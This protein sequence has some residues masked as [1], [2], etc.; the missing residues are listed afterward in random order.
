MELW[1]TL[2][3]KCARRCSCL[4]VLVWSLDRKERGEGE[5]WGDGVQSNL[6]AEGVGAADCGPGLCVGRLGAACKIIEGALANQ[7]IRPCC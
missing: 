1:L 5:V 4:A 6:K 2:M 7:K 3:A